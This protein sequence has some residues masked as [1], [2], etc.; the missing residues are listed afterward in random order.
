MTDRPTIQGS[1]EA[2]EL[3]MPPQTRRSKLSDLL[4]Q[5]QAGV[6]DE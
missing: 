6:E 2:V 5:Q 3:E 4:V 1:I